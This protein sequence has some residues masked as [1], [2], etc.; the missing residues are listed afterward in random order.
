LVGIQVFSFLWILVDYDL[1]LTIFRGGIL[2]GRLLIP[3]SF[4]RRSCEKSRS[5]PCSDDRD[6]GIG[7]G[8]TGSFSRAP[9]VACLH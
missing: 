2:T 5:S 4:L 7:K 6:V 9:R 3:R 8:A 1:D